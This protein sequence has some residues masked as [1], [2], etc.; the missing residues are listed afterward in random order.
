MS[1]KKILV[2]DD[3]PIQT[4]ML[5][6]AL[7]EA[8]YE[9]VLTAADGEEALKKL[10]YV[11]DIDLVLCDWNMPV[12]SGIDFLRKVREEET[13]KHIPLFL[14]TSRSTK[15]DLMEAIKAGATNYVVKPVQIQD[16]VRKI[17]Q[18]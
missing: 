5:S 1:V 15:K 13:T 11:R 2:I 9:A 12:M 16:L 4:H 6:K 8:G 7:K 14:V 18:L 10:S 17:E 3:S